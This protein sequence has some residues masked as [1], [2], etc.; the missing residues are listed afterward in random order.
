[1]V[2]LQS[3]KSC[4][5]RARESFVL[6][7]TGTRIHGRTKQSLAAHVSSQPTLTTQ[8]RAIYNTRAMHTE[9]CVS[10]L[11]SV[12]GRRAALQG[13]NGPRYCVGLVPQC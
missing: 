11:L 13:G 1:M 7:S 5:P 9:M 8:S 6:R 2:L 4:L 12:T 10:P 3:L